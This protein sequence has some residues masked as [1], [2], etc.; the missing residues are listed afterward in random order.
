[1][2]V[3]QN[4]R[5]QADLISRDLGESGDDPDKYLFRQ[6]VN[7]LASS[8]LTPQMAGEWFA[9]ILQLLEENFAKMNRGEQI[10]KSLLRKG[11]N[12]KVPDT[13]RL[14]FVEIQVA[15][16]GQPTQIQRNSG[17]TP[18]EMTRARPKHF[19]NSLSLKTVHK[20]RP[21]SEN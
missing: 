6:V 5:R 12:L 10:G 18:K 20:C 9:E 2:E 8:P 15:R 7:H 13:V 11:P 16:R 19:L 3:A 4:E 14:Q 21:L 17:E 1:M